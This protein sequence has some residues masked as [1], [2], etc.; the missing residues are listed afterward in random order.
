[1]FRYILVEGD[2]WLPDIGPY[3][4][5]GLQAGI[6]ERGV[7]G[8]VFATNTLTIQGVKCMREKMPGMF[9]KIKI[10]AFDESEAFSLS[11]CKISYI[12][13]PVELFGSES[14]RILLDNITNG[15]KQI[16]NTTLSPQFVEIN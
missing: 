10:V 11:D 14:V 15:T 13:Q 1:M 6:L 8:I 16:V 12:R 9:R 5:F 2:F 3:H 4:S 7:D